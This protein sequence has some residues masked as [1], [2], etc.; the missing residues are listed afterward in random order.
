MMSLQ[1][2]YKLRGVFCTFTTF[3]KDYFSR[4]LSARN[5]LCILIDGEELVQLA[6]RETLEISN[7]M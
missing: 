6:S 2:I 3:T 1:I 5:A 4:I 7:I